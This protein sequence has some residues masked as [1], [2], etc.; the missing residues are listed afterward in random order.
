MKSI[1][2]VAVITGASQGIGLETARYLTNKGYTVYGL[3]RRE[4]VGEN[5][6]TIVADVTDYETIKNIFNDIYKCE[7]QLN[8]LI[9]NAGVGSGGAVE[10]TSNDDINKIF[11]T[12]VV[13]VIQLCR[14]VLPFIRNSG[15]GRII[16]I[17]SVAGPVPVPYQACYS[18]SKSAIE[19]FSGAFDLEVRPFN[20]RVTTVIPGDTSTSFSDNRIKNKVL[21]DNNYS[22]RV[23]S[24]LNKTEQSEKNGMPAIA[25]A[26]QIHKCL[27]QKSPPITVTV[28][29]FNK[30]IIVLAKLFP[31]KILMNVVKK[32]Y[33]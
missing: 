10:H 26:K 13:A 2:K 11:D 31:K 8:Y 15:G 20:I 24:S 33:G 30:A 18:A 9:N 1:K 32:L 6:K 27:I 25:V 3:A 29:F 17:G 22:D 14:D 16:N 12:N 28:G 21:D 23:I 7:G 19:N 4:I 5:F